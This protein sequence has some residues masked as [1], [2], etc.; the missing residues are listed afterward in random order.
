[1][2]SKHTSRTRLL[3]LGVPA[4]VAVW[5][6]LGGSRPGSAGQP[7][8]AAAPAQ[9]TIV[10]APA[11]AAEE[12]PA[13]RDGVRKAIDGFVAAFRGGDGKAVAAQWTA[14]G[15]YTSD[16]GTT[17]RGRAALEKAYAEFFAKNPGNWL[18]V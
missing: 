5:L 13:D 10:G 7:P 3:L 6:A 16:D 1:M 12:R 15:E 11:A 2:S 8:A 18:D 4:A 17:F 9:P 14:G